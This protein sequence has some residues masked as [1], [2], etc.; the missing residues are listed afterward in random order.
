ML[1]LIF[2]PANVSNWSSFF[3]AELG[4]TPLTTWYFKIL[5]SAVVS[6]S[7]SASV[8]QIKFT[9]YVVV[10]F[11]WCRVHSSLQNKSMCFNFCRNFHN[12]CSNRCSFRCRCNIFRIVFDNL[13]CI[14]SD[15]L[16]VCFLFFV[17]CFL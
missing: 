11:P 9:C 1:N 3:A 15:C 7:S 13:V 14:P 12:F 17:F 10:L 16:F 4:I 6:L 2:V 5:A 8:F